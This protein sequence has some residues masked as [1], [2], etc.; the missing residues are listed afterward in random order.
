[1]ACWDAQANMPK[2][3]NYATE[4][5]EPMSEKRDIKNEMKPEV[6][7]ETD[8]KSDINIS[9]IAKSSIVKIENQVGKIFDSFIIDYED[10]MEQ[11]PTT[12]YPFSKSIE[13]QTEHEESVEPAEEDFKNEEPFYIV[14]V[15]SEHIESEDIPAGH[16]EMSEQEDFTRMLEETTEVRQ[17]NTENECSEIKPTAVQLNSSKSRSRSHRKFDFNYNNESL[18]TS[19]RVHS[20]EKRR[21]EQSSIS[22]EKCKQASNSKTEKNQSVILKRTIRKSKKARTRSSKTV[23]RKYK[24]G[25]GRSQKATASLFSSTARKDILG[26]VSNTSS[27]VSTRKCFVSLRP[28]KVEAKD[29]EMAQP[30]V[31]STGDAVKPV[32][33]NMVSTRG[34]SKSVV[35]NRPYNDTIDPGNKKSVN[36]S[37]DAVEPV[38]SNM[39]STRRHSRSVVPNSRYKDMVDP[40]MKKSDSDIDDSDADP[41][42]KPS[43]DDD[44]TDDDKNVNNNITKEDLVSASE[45]DSNDC[46]VDPQLCTDKSVTILSSKKNT[47]GNRDNKKTA[48]FL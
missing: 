47:K 28:L 8:C 23:L 12:V 9:E 41:V 4:R 7:I 32:L 20:E 45:R 19:F 5:T 15:N 33:S 40:E 39:V 26:D 10:D 38:L 18:S 29:K 34:R 24:K 46:A 37:D 35:P 44:D 30:K 1:M 27:A 13:K 2:G 36:T 31:N 14:E 43:S 48:V 16:P 3:F 11:M 42:Y 22:V 6:S 25:T 21:I 17:E